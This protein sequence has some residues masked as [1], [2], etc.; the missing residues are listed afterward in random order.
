MSALDL[1]KRG[2]VDLWVDSAD[3]TAYERFRKQY[4]N[5][6]VSFAQECVL[7]ENG[8]GLTDYQRDILYHIPRNKRVSVRGPHGLGKSMTAAIT[9]L[10]F[11]L[12]RDGDDWKIA[13]TASAWRQLE[14]F[15]WPEIHKWAR[16]LNWSRIGRDPFEPSRELLALELRLKT[17][18][19]FALASDRHELI[20]GAHADHMLYVFDEA[21]VVPEPTWDAAEGA[22]VNANS[23]WLSISTPGEPMGRFYDIQSR[24][25]GYGDWWVRHVTTREAVLAKRI[26][27]EWVEAR[28]RQWGETSSVFQN[29]VAGEFASED[30]NSVIPLSW[31]EAAQL[32]WERWR[33]QTPEGEEGT[34]EQIGIDVARQGTDL[35]VFA[36]RTGHV[37]TELVKFSKADTMETA[38]H[39][40]A[41]LIRHPHAQAVIDVIGWGAGVYDR[42]YEQYPERV[43]AFNAAESTDYEDKAGVWGFV[44]S[45]SAAWWKMRELLDPANGLEICL[46]PDDELTGDLTSPRWRVVSNGKIRVESKDSIKERLRRSTDS[47]DAVAQ[48]FFAASGGGMEAG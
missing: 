40:V 8:D 12:T 31:V 24:K 34:I 21:K 45:R 43:F 7:W 39:T 10:W 19:A 26:T 18:A 25:S 14:K 46:P 37:I 44:D 20:E 16:R 22:M 1:I 41:A 47:A 9:V 11:A 32:R 28:R 15:L 2:S 4:R 38:G 30:E 42:A 48:A 23:F 5:D 29:R 13:T 17:G 35:T 6:P 27:D 33:D 36:Y 3:K